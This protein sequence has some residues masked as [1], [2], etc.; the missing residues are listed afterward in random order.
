M[1]LFFFVLDLVALCF[2]FICLYLASLLLIDFCFSA[3][4]LVLRSGVLTRKSMYIDGIVSYLFLSDR[5]V[6]FLFFSLIFFLGYVT[7]QF[8]AIPDFQGFAI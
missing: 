4:A 7:M 2:H 3:E 6:L 5:A 1:D 8:L